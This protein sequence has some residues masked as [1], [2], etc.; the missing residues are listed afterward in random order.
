[1]GRW[2]ARFEVQAEYLSNY[3]EPFYPGRSMKLSWMFFV[4]FFLLLEK[5]SIFWDIQLKKYIL[6][7][8]QG[9]MLGIFIN[10]Y[11]L[12][13]AKQLSMVGHAY[14][15]KE[16]GAQRS[17]VTQLLHD[18]VKLGSR[19]LCHAKMIPELRYISWEILPVCSKWQK[20]QENVKVFW[21]KENYQEETY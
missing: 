17:L 11:L 15:H 10:T 3:L 21:R 2:V 8:W 6:T 18:R 14:F 19:V 13:S 12:Y 1:M 4:F 20:Y 9:R 16:F 5:E 7:E